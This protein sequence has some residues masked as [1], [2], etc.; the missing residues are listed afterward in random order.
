MLTRL[1]RPRESARLGQEGLEAIRR[2]GITSTLLTCNQIEAL[3]AVGDWDEADRL[4]AAALRGIPS[5]SRSALLTVRAQ[6][7]IGRGELDAARAHLDA[8][9]AD[10]F[11]YRMLGL[12]DCYRADLALGASLDDAAAAIDEGWLA[13]PA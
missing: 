1:G 13:P 3:L 8:A 6:V 2:Y 11:E 12:H 4:S 9:G 10:L 7:E 5:S